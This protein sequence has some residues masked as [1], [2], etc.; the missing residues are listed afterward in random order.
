MLKEV[1]MSNELA[2]R[3]CIVT[4]ANTGIGRVTALEL[5]RRGARVYLACRSEEKTKPAVD[6]IRASCGADAAHFLALD[7]ASLA[8]VRSCA[9]E[10]LSR[11][12]P[13][14][15]LVN[16]A[17]LAGQRGTTKDG[18]ETTFGVNHLGHFLLTGLLMPRL[19]AAAPAR[20][21]NVASRAHIRAKGIDFDALRRPTATVT[22]F[23][24]YCVSKL[25]N[26]LFS[27]LHGERLSGTGI[28]TYA[29]H[30]GVIASDI[31]RRVPPPFRWL[32]KAF[33]KT[34]EEGAQT[35]V[36]CAT[37]PDVAQH[38]GRYYADNQEKRVAKL[39]LDDALATRLWDLSVEWTGV[40]PAKVS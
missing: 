8:S 22:G 7:L 15:I 25:C 27:R 6:E 37:S 18:F 30:P 38:T 36:Y 11:G 26:V 1:R 4:G 5:A 20:I 21:V 16:N 40:D 34:N 14:H 28:T 39:A 12:E 2:G 31:W 17:G 35:S 23:P 24:E 29:V 32:I 10:F 13:L 3:S 19:R 33:M 9:E